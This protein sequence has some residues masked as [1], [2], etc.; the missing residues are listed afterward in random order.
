MTPAQLALCTGCPREDLA[1]YWLPPIIQAMREFGVDTPCRKA[2]FLAQVGHESGYLRF[3]EELWGPT[4]AQ[5]AYEGRTS[6]GNY[7]PGDGYKFR[8][9]G[10]IQITGRGNYTE[11]GKALGLDLVRCPSLLAE[12]LAAA[13]SAGWFWRQHGLNKYADRSDFEGL[14][15]KINGGLNGYIDRCALWVTAQ[16]VLGCS[17]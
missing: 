15:R 6:L 1:G 11:V 5:K 8:G 3:V 12:P 16:E 4:P 7:E 17:T 9:R 14:T 13:R 2:A 10:L